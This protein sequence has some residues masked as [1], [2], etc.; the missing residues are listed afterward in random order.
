MTFAIDNKKMLRNTIA[1]Y[2]RMMFTM[3][4]GFFTTRVTLQQL[5]VEDYGLNNLVGSIV[6]MF[7]FI[8]SS[9]GT[10]VQR[11]YSFEIGKGNA[12]Y[13]KRVFGT[14][15]YLHIIVAVITFILAETF[16]IYFLHRMNIP[17][18]RL[19]AAQVVFQ[20]SILSLVLGIVNVPYAALLRA[21]EMFD[22]TAMVEVIQALLRLGILYML[23][24][25]D[26]DKLIIY[27]LLGFGVSLYYVGSLT[28]LAR[29]FEESHCLPVRDKDLI[30]QMLTFISMLLITVLCQLATT[31]GMVILINSF[32][33][34]VVNAA[35][36]VAVQVSHLVNTFAASFKQSMLPQMMAAYGAKDYSSMH[37][38][39]NI[40]T[41]ITFLLMLMIT[42]PIIAEVNFL[43]EFWLNT[44]PEHAST[45]VALV[46][47]QINISSFTYFQYQGVHASGN[48]KAQQIW[49]S[50]SYLMNLLLIF[51]VLKMG[52]HFEAAI[53]VNMVVSL[54]QCVVNL[55]Y[56]HKNYQYD[57]ANFLRCILLPSC[58]LMAL[59]TCII[60]VITRMMEPS[61]GRFLITWLSSEIVII[62]FGYIIL[63][64]AQERLKIKKIINGIIKK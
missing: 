18:D 64:D 9:M 51:I 46:L 59:C 22:K 28:Y 53:Y 21:R 34:L 26:Y 41:K 31:Q 32:F 5:G 57:I 54:I 3:A 47:V 37:R 63:L 52:A 43:L 45:L 19:F 20:V 13:L 25:I 62:L 10:A 2:L 48:I 35:Y 38:I 8:N 12:G 16:A 50:C 7:S 60:H 40:G 17:E 49:M 29:R 11:F 36:A 4:I 15:L 58:T 24:I 14:G 6:S 30:K 39:I 1:L 44:P 61:I 42:V 23:T 55:R 27:S 33:G 56:S